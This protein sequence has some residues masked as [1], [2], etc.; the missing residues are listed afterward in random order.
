M[1]ERMKYF[2]M[3]GPIGEIDQA[4]DKYLTGYD[5]H[6]EN[7]FNNEYN[8]PFGERLISSGVLEDDGGAAADFY[9][10]AKS[11]VLASDFY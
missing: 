10:T 11:G 4:V 9:N 2:S 6:F 8:I 1:I 7:A 5:I 3:V